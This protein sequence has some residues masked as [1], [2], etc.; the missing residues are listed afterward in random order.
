VLVAFESAASSLCSCPRIAPCFSVLLLLLLLC[1]CAVTVAVAVVA[2]AVLHRPA[3]CCMPS[4]RRRATPDP[5]VPAP[6]HYVSMHALSAFLRRHGIGTAP[7]EHPV[8]HRFLQT[9]KLRH[10]DAG[11][12]CVRDFLKE[13]AISGVVARALLATLVVPSVEEFADSISTMLGVAIVRAFGIAAAL[14][15]PYTAPRLPRL[16]H[17]FLLRFFELTLS[18]SLH[19]T[20]LHCTPPHCTPPRYFTPPHCTTPH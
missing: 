17:A 11:V 13:G 19:S 12:V 9:V 3:P 18:T 14:P 10:A 8:V 16:V 7:G 4:P 6:K 15:P 20:L 1:A 5:L 2:A